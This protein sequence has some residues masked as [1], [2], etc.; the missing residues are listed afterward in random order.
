MCVSSGIISSFP[1]HHTTVGVGIPVTKHRR[2]VVWSG[3]ANTGLI[4]STNVGASPKISSSKMCQYTALKKN[5]NKYRYIEK[6][7]KFV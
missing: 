6:S 1:R 5:I 3:F 4:G 7:L 2:T